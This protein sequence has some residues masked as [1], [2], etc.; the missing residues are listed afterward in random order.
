M[1]D[2]DINDRGDGKIFTD[3]GLA[4]IKEAGKRLSSCSPELPEEMP[5]CRPVNP[6]YPLMIVG[7]D[8]DPVV[9]THIQRLALQGIVA[10]VVSPERAAQ[11]S[12]E[13][14]ERALSNIS[15]MKENINRMM[16]EVIE[17][18][19]EPKPN[20]IPPKMSARQF[21]K[22]TQALAFTPLT[23]R[24]ARRDRRKRNRG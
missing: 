17:A 13:A 18:V 12:E 15:K 16:C 2:I 11:I 9:Q 3:E 19:D 21:G 22:V 5:G 23:G 7:Y 14:R 6:V 4:A 8:T 24:R 1:D 10:I 20:P